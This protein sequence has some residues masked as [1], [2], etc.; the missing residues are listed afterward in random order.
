MVFSRCFQSP[1][2]QIAW[3]LRQR[4]GIALCCC[5]LCVAAPEARAAELRCHYDYGGEHA[6][7]A[8]K[9]AVDPYTAGSVAVGSFLRLRMVWQRAPSTLAALHVYTYAVG[10]DGPVIVHQ[11][12]WPETQF[13]AQGP[14]GFTGLQRAYEPPGAS[15]VQYW[16]EA[17]P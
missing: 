5:L 7:L 14:Y 12:S 10:P 16:C 11:G 8:I 6:V 3:L 4:A 9:P 13:A 2:C 1:Q 15:E 17:P